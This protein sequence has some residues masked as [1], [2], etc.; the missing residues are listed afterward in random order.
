MTGIGTYMAFHYEGM[1]GRIMAQLGS[2]LDEIMSS[3]DLM[4]R[5]LP[6]PIKTDMRAPYIEIG[7]GSRKSV[8]TGSK[9]LATGEGRG[10]AAQFMQLTEAAHYPIQSPF[11]AMLPL[12][13]RSLDSFLGI[14]STPSPDRRGIAFKEMWD[15]A[16]WVHEKRRDALFVRY[17]CPWMKDPYAFADPTIAKDAPIDEDE[18]ALMKSGVERAQI[19]W[20]RQEIRGRYRGKKELFEMENP[21][22]PLSCFSQVELPA[23][24]LEEREFAVRNVTD[25][26][27]PGTFL[28]RAEK[29]HVPV[30]FREEDNGVWRLY[31]EPQKRCEYYVGVDAARG[32]DAFHGGDV[33]KVTDFAAIVVINGSTGAVAA[34]MEAR[35]PP[36]ATAKQVALAGKYYRTPEI[37]EGHFALLNI[38]I[39]DGFGNEVQRRVIHDYDYPLT[40]FLRWRGRDDRIH[41]RP[42]QNIGWIDT[43]MTNEMRLNTFRIG[44]YN[45][46]IIVR[47]ARLAEQI[48]AA[49]MTSSGD[50][51]NLRGHDDVLDAAMYAWIARDQERPRVIVDVDETETTYYRTMI[52]FANDPQA[53]FNQLWDQLQNMVHPKRGNAV[54][55]IVNHINEAR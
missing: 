46:M 35:T 7:K 47:D 9:A 23:F 37:S 31:E 13:P 14:E 8:I 32:Y 17:F 55:T 39:T 53:R 25:K 38:A 26:F 33:R 41:G 36:D 42:G 43:Q 24:S 49:S 18:R 6:L 20:R 45:K 40:R 30:R 16:R 34:V 5:G 19:A 51:E 44:L 21:S 1:K 15:A 54:D 48:S 2:T 3:M 27:R 10:G 4:A 11:T 50:A 28:P 52:R 22:D 29:Q 12:V